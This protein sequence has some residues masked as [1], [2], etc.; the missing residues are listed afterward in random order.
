[1]VVPTTAPPHTLPPPHTH[2]KLPIGKALV[3]WFVFCLE[4]LHSLSQCLGFSPGSTFDFLLTCNL[5]NSANGSSTWVTTA[6]GEGRELFLS[7]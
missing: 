6:H 7:S 2:T 5:G 3:P 4:Q 1:M